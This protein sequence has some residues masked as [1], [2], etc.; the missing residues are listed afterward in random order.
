MKLTKYVSITKCILFSLLIGTSSTIAKEPENSLISG[1]V[2][3]DCLACPEMSVIPSGTFLM[4]STR[5]KKRELP[6]TKITIRNPLAVSRYEITFDEWDACY[7]ARGCS[8][9]PSDRGW[10]RGKRPV[11]N[12]LL[13]DI[14]EYLSWLTKKTGHVYR[15]PSESEWEYAARAGSQ[16]EFSWGNQMQIGAAN[17]RNCGTE[18]SGL[19]SAPVGQFK[20]NAWGLYDVHGN[21]L[22]YVTDCWTTSHDKVPTDGSPIITKGCLSK[23]VKGGAWYYLPKV[24]RSASRARN[25]KRVFSYFIGFR[26][27]RE[28][29]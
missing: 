24:S 19:K 5:G 1:T 23:V 12:V 17:C 15:L 3:R 10:G 13:T 11:I 18:W 20:P 25:D 28:I 6:V 4:G 21:V 9:R 8:K 7:T 27:F 26:A 14:A 16:T 22:E 29:D 2:F